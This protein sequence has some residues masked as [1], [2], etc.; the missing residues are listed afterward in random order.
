MIIIKNLL[1]Q[2]LP[3]TD[4]NGKT[5]ILS[6]REKREIDLDEANLPEAVKGLLDKEYIKI[7]KQK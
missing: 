2:A 4:K 1:Y 5:I 6:A 7:I 3:I